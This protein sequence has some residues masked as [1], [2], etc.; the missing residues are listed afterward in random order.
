MRLTMA[1][2]NRLHAGTFGLPAQRAY[3]MPDAAHARVAKSRAAQQLNAGRI[4]SADKNRI[5]SKADRMLSAIA[6][7]H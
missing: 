7:G 4:T 3:P 2:R 5:D 6:G 1:Q